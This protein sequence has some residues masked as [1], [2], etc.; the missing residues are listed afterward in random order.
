M[1]ELKEKF[2]KMLDN[3]GNSPKLAVGQSSV[4]V[5]P[6]VEKSKSDNKLYILI[7][8]I[9]IAVLLFKYN[10]IMDLLFGSKKHSKIAQQIEDYE[11]DDDEHS[12]CDDQVHEEIQEE[13]PKPTQ[14]K[15]VNELTTKSNGKTYKKNKDPL[16]QEF[17]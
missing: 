11:E 12:V 7:M 10:D 17:E 6:P 1:T 13:V 3:S 8:L 15:I 14:K 4:E 16:F 2:E 5:C 9:V